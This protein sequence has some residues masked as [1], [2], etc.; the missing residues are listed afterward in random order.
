MNPTEQVNLTTAM[1]PDNQ[2]SGMHPAD[3]QAALR[4]AGVSQQDIAQK[5][6]VSKSTVS[7]V[8]HGISKSRRIAE[9]IAIVIGKEIA[10][11]WPGSYEQDDGAI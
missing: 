5:Y 10:N 1:I 11:I 2:S 6:D 8:I 9:E 3:I 4:K 7:Q